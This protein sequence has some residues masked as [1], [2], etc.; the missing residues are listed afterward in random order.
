MVPPLPDKLTPELVFREYAP[1][2]YNL[3]RRMLGNDADPVLLRLSQR[4]IREAPLR[5]L[6]SMSGGTGSIKA[7]DGLTKLLSALR[8]TGRSRF[9]P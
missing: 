7:F 6:V 5:F 2:I 9:R 1:R 3:A 4:M 8:I